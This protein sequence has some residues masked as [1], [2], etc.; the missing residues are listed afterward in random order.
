MSKDNSSSPRLAKRRLNRTLIVASVIIGM[1]FIAAGIALKASL[2]DGSGPARAVAREYLKDLSAGDDVSAL[3]I[4]HPNLARSDVK[5]AALQTQ[6][7]GALQEMDFEDSTYFNGSTPHR[8]VL[9]RYR[10]FRQWPL[11]V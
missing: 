5:A 2:F 9:Q 7:W 11:A 6:H 8:V 10:P 4:A 3:A 1:F